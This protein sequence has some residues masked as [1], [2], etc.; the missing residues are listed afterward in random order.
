MGDLTLVLEDKKKNHFITKDGDVVMIDYGDDNKEV[1]FVSGSIRLRN[2]DTV[3]NLL[4]KLFERVESLP[5]SC[6]Y[7]EMVR[8]FPEF[9]DRKRLSEKQIE[10]LLIKEFAGRVIDGQTGVLLVEEYLGI[11]VGEDFNLPDG[12]S[13]KQF[14][15]RCFYDFGCEKFLRQSEE[16]QEKNVER[17]YMWAWQN[18]HFKNYDEEAA[19]QQLTGV[20]QKLK[21]LN[22]QLKGLQINEGS[23]QTLRNA[24]DGVMYGF[25]LADIELFCNEQEKTKRVG[26]QHNQR[27]YRE[28]A[29]N[30]LPP[31][32]FPWVLSTETIVEMGKKYRAKQKIIALEKALKE[33]EKTSVSETSAEKPKI[34]RKEKMT[35]LF[36]RLWKGKAHNH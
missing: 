11:K 4:P 33:Q 14:H 22:P 19:K 26:A 35:Q 7:D 5:D 24:I 34:S 10:K 28:I 21:E 1:H 23:L 12:L 17:A 31:V 16:F 8:L 36:S 27:I 18:L 15:M 30:G 25:P 2:R 20:Y 13:P 32:H 3:S 29:E 6:Y 9:K